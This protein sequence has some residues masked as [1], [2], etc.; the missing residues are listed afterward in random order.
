MYGTYLI[1]EDTKLTPIKRAQLPKKYTSGNYNETRGMIH[2]V[3]YEVINEYL[4]LLN[5]YF[6]KKSESIVNDQDYLTTNNS[7]IKWSNMQ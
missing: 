7:S 3:S 4:V 6:W 1:L 5:S 2:I